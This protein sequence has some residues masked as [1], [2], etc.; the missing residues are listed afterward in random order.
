LKNGLKNMSSLIVQVKK[1]DE[2]KPHSNAEKLELLVI[3]GWQVVEKKGVYKQG[4]L[5][6]FIPPDS[7]VP[8]AVAAKYNVSSYLGKNGRVKAVRLRGEASFGLL[9]PVQD[10]WKEGTDVASHFG[11]TKY[12]PA[13]AGT[14]GGAYGNKGGG[15]APRHPLWQRYTEVEN[16]RHYPNIIV[17]GTEV[18]WLEKI[19]G[20]QVNIGKLDGELIVGSRNFCRYAP[21]RYKSLNKLQTLWNK[22]AK[23]L[24]DSL[25]FKPR[26]YYDEADKANDWYWFPTTKFSV[27]NLINNLGMKYKQVILYGET[28]GKVQK[29]MEYGTPDALQFRAYD[30]L[31]DGHFVSHDDF[32]AICGMYGVDT[33]PVVARG[34]YSFADTLKYANGMTECGPSNQIREGV[35]VKPVV[36]VANPKAGRVIFKAIND[37]YLIKQ[38]TKDAVNDF[39]EE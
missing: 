35:V 24:D 32:M 7:C 3:G 21:C 5:T 30:L 10:K 38:F 15:Q 1:I 13:V 27:M 11:I 6:V 31:L 17:D 4:D 8:E 20:C 23:L 16:V 34:P 37:D 28:Y 33:A 22:Y 2:V 19:H 14:G 25:M 29:G 12:E 9:L 18:V 26:K 36:P 39:T